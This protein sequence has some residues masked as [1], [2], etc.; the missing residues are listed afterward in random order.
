MSIAAQTASAL[1]RAG[2]IAGVAVAISGWLA[3]TLA[4]LRGRAK[5]VAWALLLAPFFTP[6]LLISYA[7]SRLA[8]ALVASP[9]SHHALYASVLLLKLV[10][11]AVVARTLMPSPLSA[12]A[13]HC[14]HLLSA[15]S[16]FESVL[17]RLRGADPAPCFAGGLVFLLAFAD[18]ELASLWSIK[19]WTV[20]LFDA[21]TGGLAWRES[22]RIAA[23]PLAIQVAV[24]ALLASCKTDARSAPMRSGK[25]SRAALCYL[26]AV[27][28]VV[29]L[30]PLLIVS[31][32]A[33]A[34]FR[35]VEENFVL[36][37]EIIASA[38]FAV[39]AAAISFRV[40]SSSRALVLA[41]LRNELC[42]PSPT[43]RTRHHQRP[44]LKVR[45]GGTPKPTLGTSVLPG[46]PGLLGSLMLA[47]L[48]LALFQIPLLRPLYDTPL[49]LVLALTILL[50]PLAVLLKIG[51]MGR[52]S[53]MR[54]IARQI[55]S[56]RLRWELEMQ[57]RLAAFALLFCGAY[58][59]FTASA[60]LAPTRFTPV[61]VRLH[62]LAHYGQTAVLS[63]MMLAAFAVPILLLLLTIAAGQIYARRDVR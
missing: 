39:G 3:P 32:Q 38:L 42:E 18:F 45:E 60:I 6:A 20:V 15:P 62:N 14:H 53:P 34:G 16:G 22:L 63:A 37:N 31:V 23:W 1:F 56:R 51:L 13:R 61:F 58:F 25:T 57:P 19:T 50:L 44:A 40:A 9:Q 10:P 35:A 29:C 2:C 4:G 41:S 48:V 55:G 46:V 12:E 54:H 49:P 59:D 27:A 24:L 52:M 7:F 47:L 26:A 11:V 33:A 36:G 17:F 43:D 5:S 28:G 30:L 8:L 21:Q